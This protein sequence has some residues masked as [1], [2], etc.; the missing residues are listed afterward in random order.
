[1]RR[2]DLCR[3]FFP[4]FFFSFSYFIFFILSLFCCTNLGGLGGGGKMGAG[5]GKVHKL[6]SGRA[7]MLYVE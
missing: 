3:L 5:K 6:S 7:E 4:F 2:E 1:M